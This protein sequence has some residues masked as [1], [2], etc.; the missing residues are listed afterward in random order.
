MQQLFW[1]I[2]EKEKYQFRNIFALKGRGKHTISI[3]TLEKPFRLSF[4]E[5]TY[6][7]FHL[8]GR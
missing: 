4:S 1:K 3:N 7:K 5:A 8:F 2:N 6:P